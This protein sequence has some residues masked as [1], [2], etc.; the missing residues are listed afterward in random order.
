MAGWPVPTSTD[1]NGMPVSRRASWYDERGPSEPG[2]WGE[3]HHACIAFAVSPGVLSRRGD[4]TRDV[5]T[6]SAGSG[7]LAVIALTQ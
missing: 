3:A 4:I 6:T 1:T 7:C 5:I 2:S